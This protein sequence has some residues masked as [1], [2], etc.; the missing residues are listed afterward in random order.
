MVVNT[1]QSMKRNIPGSSRGLSSEKANFA[2]FVVDSGNTVNH[3]LKAIT[4][5]C[6][7]RLLFLTLILI[8]IYPRFHNKPMLLNSEHYAIT[9]LNL[10]IL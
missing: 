4:G 7:N 9:L 8:P 1:G 3:P 5:S 6:H 2:Q 10:V